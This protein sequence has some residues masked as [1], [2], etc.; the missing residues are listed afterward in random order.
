MKE[1]ATF[2]FPFS[3]RRSVWLSK[4][5]TFRI[6]GPANYFKEIHSIS[7]AQQVIHF[8]HSENYPFIIVGKGSNCLFD[9]QGF[10]GF[11]LFNSIQGKE[12]LSDTTV[13]VYSG[14]SFSHLGK[15]LSSSGYSGLEFAVGIP[16][17][18]GGAVFMNAG[19]GDQDVASVLESVEVINA[20]G[21]IC[22]Y[23]PQQL[24]FG[25]R[26]SRFQTRKEFI[27]SAT[28]KI[29]RNSGALQLAKDL[30]QRRLAS[31]PYQQPSAG[32]IFRNPPGDSAGK[33]ID[34]AGLK[35]LSLGGAQ[36]SP[37][38]ANFIV[39]TGRATAYEVKQLIQM[40]RDKLQSQGIN[41]EEEIRIIPYRLP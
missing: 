2:H 1:S 30:L 29:S 27:L 26:K 4:Y 8:L 11:V 20:E 16:G 18:V 24:D 38:H 12:F 34:E 32:C 33:L 31:Q 5:S 36:I 14:M 13:K 3:V 15:T 35:G 23:T 40:V 28:F 21:E 6:G 9:D 22:S 39:N 37:K 41:L 17:S 19:I 25:Y 10:D 7:E